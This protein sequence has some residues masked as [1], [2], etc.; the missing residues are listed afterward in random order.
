MAFSE[1][2]YKKVSKFVKTIKLE[3]DEFS[4]FGID[5]ALLICPSQNDDKSKNG[6]AAEYIRQPEEWVIYLWENIGEKIQRSLLFH[7]IVEIYHVAQKM[8]Q[9][10]A[11]NA[12]MPLEKRFCEE[13]LTSSELE[14]YLNFKKE[15]GCDGFEL[16][17]RTDEIKK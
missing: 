14:N 6:E 1:S 8:K 5:Y 12:T 15:Q 4:L 17:K 16:S 7:E 11:H 10:P 2:K 9:T 13:Y 3:D